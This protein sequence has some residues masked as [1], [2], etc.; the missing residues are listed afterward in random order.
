[1]EV[2]AI[3]S[4]YVI[5]ATITVNPS[6]PSFIRQEPKSNLLP[7][8]IAEMPRDHGSAVCVSVWELN[9]DLM[10]FVFFFQNPHLIMRPY[11]AYH[12]KPCACLLCIS[13]WQAC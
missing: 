12:T 7:I 4:V 9:V 11:Q 3:L 5:I 8:E 1:M 13:S 2:L 10:L 6:Q